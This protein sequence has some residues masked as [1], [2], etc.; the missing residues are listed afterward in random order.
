MKPKLSAVV[1]RQTRPKDKPY[2]LTDGTEPYL[3][4]NNT[5][6]YWRYDYRHQCKRKTLSYGVYPIITLE[7]ARQAP[8]VFALFA[9]TLSGGIFV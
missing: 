2:K 7:V 3:L 6:K 4:V 8:S 9:S 5:G 1:V